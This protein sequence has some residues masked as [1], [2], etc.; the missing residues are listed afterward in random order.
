MIL[1]P[2]PS[3]QNAESL[4]ARTTSGT[5]WDDFR[6][7]LLAWGGDHNY[8]QLWF[9]A[10]RAVAAGEHHWLIFARAATEKDVG[11]AQEATRPGFSLPAR[12]KQA[13]Q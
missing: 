13:V 7:A 10:H 8:P 4:E 2:S 12:N 1:F 3:A 9:E 11:L 6:G 5:G